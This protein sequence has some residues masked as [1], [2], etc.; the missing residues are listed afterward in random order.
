[1]GPILKK[2][3]IAQI[4]LLLSTKRTHGLFCSVLFCPVPRPSRPF[5]GRKICLRSGKI[6]FQLFMV[7]EERK[8]LGTVQIEQSVSAAKQEYGPKVSFEPVQIFDLFQCFGSFYYKMD[9]VLWWLKLRHLVHFSF[10]LKFD[11]KYQLILLFYI[12]SESFIMTFFILYR[13]VISIIPKPDLHTYIQCTLGRKKR[14]RSEWSQPTG[15]VQ[16]VQQQSFP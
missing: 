4:G 5:Y 3:Q 10:S 11:W 14:T 1:M 7:P 8:R 15:T 16:E 12:T 2:V 9:G 13:H 6:A